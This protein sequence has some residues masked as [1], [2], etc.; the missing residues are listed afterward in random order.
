MK[1]CPKCKKMMLTRSN[2]CKCGYLLCYVAARV[3]HFS[4]FIYYTCNVF[5][6]DHLIVITCSPTYS[7]IQSSYSLYL[8]INILMLTG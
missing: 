4:A 1:K 3:L 6:F 8:E 7:S 5:R 2:N